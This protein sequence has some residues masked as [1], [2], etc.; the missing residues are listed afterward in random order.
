M[1]D[2]L[3]TCYD[4]QKAIRVRVYNKNFAGRFV[5]IR[6]HA[7]HQDGTAR[8]SSFVSAGFRR[9]WYVSS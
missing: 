3:T 9:V 5:V 6:Q 8:V 1:Q 2:F 4:Y 7:I